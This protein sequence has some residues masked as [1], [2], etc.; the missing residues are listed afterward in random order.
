MPIL[1]I[2]LC[3]FADHGANVVDASAAGISSLF[4]S[5]LSLSDVLSST[6]VGSLVFNIILS[7]FGAHET[8]P[9]AMN[10]PSSSGSL[11]VARWAF[12]P[13]HSGSLIIFLF[14]HR[15]KALALNQPKAPYQSLQVQLVV[16]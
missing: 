3:L 14:Q 6:C 12:W 5:P 10:M 15:N 1:M 16:D 2:L 13:H 11:P 8:T 9:I 7:A 4:L